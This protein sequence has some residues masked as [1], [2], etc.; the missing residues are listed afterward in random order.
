VEADG[1]MPVRGAG[2]KRPNRQSQDQ[3]PKSKKEA[4]KQSQEKQERKAKRQAKNQE[5]EIQKARKEGLKNNNPTGR[6]TTNPP[7]PCLG[8]SFLIPNVRKA[9]A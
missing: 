6:H 9:R 7:V 4:K 3:K 8:R 5:K 1:G 2:K